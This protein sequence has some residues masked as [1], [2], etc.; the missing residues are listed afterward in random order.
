MGNFI[1]L[2]RIQ[3]CGSK[4]DL[5]Y[6]NVKP[7]LFISL[8]VDIGLHQYASRKIL[9]VLSHK[10]LQEQIV[11]SLNRVSFLLSRD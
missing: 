11:G 9:A 5:T 2:Y 8:V 3:V 7:L 10:V 1:A 6:G 4:S